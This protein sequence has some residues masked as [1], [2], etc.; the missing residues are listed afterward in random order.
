MHLDPPDDRDRAF[1][2]LLS[3]LLDVSS[4]ASCPAGFVSPDRLAGC[5]P[6]EL[7]HAITVYRQMLAQDR[8]RLAA[9]RGL[10]IALRLLGDVR[11]AVV[12]F[13]EGLRLRKELLDRPAQRGLDLQAANAFD[14][15]IEHFRA[16][17]ASL[18]GIVAL[19]FELGKTLMAA[20]DLVPA[21][22]AFAEVCR[23]DPGDQAARVALRELRV[24]GTDG[25]GGLRSD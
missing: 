1:T 20:G 16:A 12:T 11:A 7:S 4:Q 13:E 8:T 10:G 9:Y 24:G 17:D 22:R 19:D 25:R 3:I 18:R 15:A 23:L 5:S 14:E 2:A 21:A 6:E